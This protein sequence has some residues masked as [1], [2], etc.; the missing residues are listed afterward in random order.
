MPTS[1]VKPNLVIVM[2]DEH[3][4]RTISAYRDHLLTKHDIEH[5]DVWGDGVYSKTHWIDTLAKEGALYSNFYSVAPLCT[6]SRASFMTGMYPQFVGAEFNHRPMDSNFKTFADIL[7]DQRGYRTG[8]MGKWHLDGGAKPGWGDNGRDFGFDYNT[9][10]FN[11]GHWKYF[12]ETNGSV[13]EYKSHSQFDSDVDGSASKHFATDFLVDR[14]IEF[15]QS[16]VSDN[17]PFA[18]MISIPDPHGPNEVR[19]PFS[20]QF[21]NEYFKYP[22]TATANLKADPASPVWNYLNRDDYPF[23]DVDKYVQD[24]EAGS[25]WQNQLQQYFGM[26]ANIDY[27]MGK[28]LYEIRAAG[29]EDNTIVIFTSDHGDLL[30]EHGKVNKGKPYET[31]AGIP[32]LIKYPDK[33]QAGKVVETPYSTVDFAPTLLSLM[34]IKDL[35]QL[36]FQGVDGSEELL[37][38]SLVSKN[39]DKIIFTMDTGNTPTWAAAVKD[40]HKFIVSSGSKPYLFDVNIDPDELINYID[41]PNHAVVKAELQAALGEAL[42]IYDIPMTRNDDDIYLEIP[43]CFDSSDVLQLRNGQKVLCKDMGNN[44]FTNDCGDW[45]VNSH[46]PK[47]CGTCKCEDSVGP[48]FVGGEVKTCED[49]ADQCTSS[50]N[51]RDFC[52]KTC[53]TCT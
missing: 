7:R 25:Y 2:T 50:W 34:N 17:E 22:K 6:P 4:L 51:V 28:L 39:D 33:I 20:T 3:N 30:G 13:Q 42:V 5:V 16:A 21:E 44:A 47:T 27:N 38:S 53:S 52:R 48:I 46:C 12:V 19:R 18:L 29:Q 15:I 26:V 24:Y 49:L 9:Y 23:D 36:T 10:R 1:P 37:N 11:R 14:G 45:N 31:S 43:A 41:S 8:Y 35:S 40:G 32:F